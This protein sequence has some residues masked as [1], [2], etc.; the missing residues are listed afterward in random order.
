MT[1]CFALKHAKSLQIYIFVVCVKYHA[2]ND[3]P[4]HV[5]RRVG[6]L[7]YTF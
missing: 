6:L 1:N 2:K 3:F 7:R 5:V 4:K